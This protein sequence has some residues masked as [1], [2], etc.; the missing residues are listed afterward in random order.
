LVVKPP[1]NETLAPSTAKLG[2]IAAETTS[3]GDAANADTIRMA[4][5]GNS[6]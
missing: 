6:K 1:V 5:T 3:Y 2:V 4:K